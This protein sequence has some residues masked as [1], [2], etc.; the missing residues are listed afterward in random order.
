MNFKKIFL[1]L[2]CPFLLS[3]CI[4]LRDL[5]YVQPSENTQL[6]EYGLIPV[7]YE[8]YRIKKDDILAMTLIT[9]DENASR[10]LGTENTSQFKGAG[11]S[12]AGTNMNLYRI[13]GLAV[14]AEGNINIYGLGEFHVYGLT[15][16]EVRKIVQARLDSILY[17]EGKAEVRINMA[18]I[19]YIML[20]EINSPGEKTES[21]VRVDLLSAIAKAGDLTR[22]ADRKRIKI[23]REYPEGKKFITLDITKEDIMNSPYFY[24]Q[25]GDQIVIDPRR[26]KVTGVGGGTALGDV[27]QF[28]SVGMTAITTYLFFKSL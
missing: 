9:S 17:N 3:S 28:L 14:S 7:T 19:R 10:F 11:G 18:S 15:L 22:F 21:D 24:L 27:L 8:V 16:E 2:F 5:K 25:S 4:G 6:N 13:N 26:E 20:G 1:L 12:G 23:I